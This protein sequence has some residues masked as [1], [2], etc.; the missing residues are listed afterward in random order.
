MQITGV[1]EFQEEFLDEIPVRICIG[2]S[3]RSFR[4]EFPE[5]LENMA[6]EIIVL[7]SGSIPI[8][9]FTPCLAMSTSSMS[10]FDHDIA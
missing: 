8:S 1:E 6:G 4:R 3:M 7:C 5:F 9:N 2:N 10:N